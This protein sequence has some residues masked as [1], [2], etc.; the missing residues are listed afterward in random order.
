MNSDS[1]KPQSPFANLGKSDRPSAFVQWNPL[2]HCV[3]PKLP[4]AMNNTLF[5]GLLPSG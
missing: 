4:P 5:N 1:L 2:L 3:A